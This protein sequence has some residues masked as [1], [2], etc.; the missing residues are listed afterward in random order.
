MK[1][2]FFQLS[3]KNRSTKWP[4]GT[5][6]EIDVQIKDMTSITSPVLLIQSFAPVFY[7]YAYIEE[8]RR[9]YF[10]SNAASVEGMWEASLTE[11]YLA[12]FRAYIL[13]TIA[14][15]LYAT[16]SK[17]SIPDS[18]IPV[19][20][21]VKVGHNFQA[22]PEVTVT[23]GMGAVILGLTGKGSFGTYLMKDSGLVAELLDGV[24]NWAQSFITDNWN[25]TLQLFFGGSAGECLKSAIAIPLVFD[26]SEV[27]SGTEV[28]LVLGNY[29]CKDHNNNP[30]TGYKI[31]KPIL[32]FGTSIKIPWQSTDWKK[33]AA[34]S[35]IKMYFPFIGIITLPATELQ[36]DENINYQIVL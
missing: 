36:N 26:V 33:V 12:T 4:E 32:K 9:F 11:D 17:K 31:T 22:L 5:S 21:T 35:T 28:D 29:P 34:Y 20:S 13:E 19:K 18:R 10:I 14:N 2:R 6:H 24:D 15:V 16:D 27:S 8:W 7:N 23:E 1:V 25:F 3:K 30:I